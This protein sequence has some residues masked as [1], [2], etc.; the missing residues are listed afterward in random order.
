[1]KK[2]MLM[3]LTVLI[4]AGLF[5][6]GGQAGGAS[7]A[8]ATG[9]GFR[10]TG[11]P[12]NARDV[13]ITWAE[14]GGIPLN[15]RVA[16]AA[17][18]PFHTW[19]SELSGVNIEWIFPTAGSG[20]AQTYAL[21]IASGD[22]PDVMNYGGIQNEAERLIEEGTIWDLT[23][24]M[25]QYS[26]NYY[27]YIKADPLRDKA[28]K[29]DSGKYYRYGFFREE[30]PF[31]DTWVG[32]MVRKD[33][34]D[35][36][37]LP[38]P[39]TIADWDRTLQVFKDR[40][41]AMLTFEKGFGNYGGLCGA[42]GA[43]TMYNFQW[44]VDG[45]G[46][47]QAANVQNEYRNYL[48]KL[49][50]WWVKG[51]LDPD[52]LTIDQQTFRAKALDNKV[53]ISFGAISR[54]TNLVNDSKAANNGAEWIGLQYPKGND[55]TLSM[56][57]G[58]W[59]V[60][61]GDSGFITTGCPPEKLEIAMRLW[62]FGFTEEGFLFQNYGKKGDSWEYDASGKIVFT[63]KIL[64][65]PD[66]IDLPTMITRYVGQRSSM[67][68]LQ[69]THLAELVNAPVSFE[70]AKTW[71]YPNEEVAYKHMPPPGITLTISETDR[72][73][74]LMNAINTY[75]S[76]MAVSFVTGQTSLSEFNN[77]V[78]RLNQMGLAEAQ[79]IQQAG[80]DRWNAR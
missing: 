60:G 10:F 26:P 8:A 21:I 41:G 47:I 56:V 37:N 29:T 79:R 65:D 4:T 33:W 76:E 35:A 11:Y 15:S 28:Q 1:M 62:D 51:Y 22:L 54:V 64:N 18:S 73:S 27:K 75:A 17:D 74:E 34:L 9:S 45:N 36:N 61:F 46:R 69:A 72:Y 40:Y 68:G 43:Y 55:G 7:G 6:G 12:M 38:M 66:A 77:F 80:L 59:G 16:S 31:L 39:Q 2:I 42:F 44:F 3:V 14:L 53:G 67:P 58:N 71:F 57:Q 52:H 49:N 19:Y 20:A 63:P 24:Y 78:N 5:A 25:E 30:G 50:E 48:A 13:T 70:A 23:P 32:P